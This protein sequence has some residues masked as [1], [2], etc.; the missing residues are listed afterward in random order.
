MRPTI[1]FY[2]RVEKDRLAADRSAKVYMRVTLDNVQQ[3]RFSTG[4]SIPIRKEFQNMTEEDILSFPTE[5]ADEKTGTRYELFHW[6]NSSSKATKGCGNMQEINRSIDR[7]K[8]RANKAIDEL[9]LMG[10]A[11]TAD[12]FG[13]L[14]K[15][16]TEKISF[17]DY[18]YN[19]LFGTQDHTLTQHTIKTYEAVIGK[20]DNYKPGVKMRDIDV[21]FLTEYQ[22]W[23]LKPKEY[24]V[25]GNN[26]GGAGN[27]QRTAANNLK[28]ISTM[29]LMAVRNGDFAE[30]FYPFMEFKI[31]GKDKK[32]TTRD[33]LEIEEIQE[34][35]KLYRAYY[36]P[37]NEN[38]KL[39]SHAEWNERE[40]NRIIT[41]GEFRV[42]KRFLISCYTSLRFSDT[43][44]LDRKKHIFSKYV[45]QKN[46]EEKL[47]KYYI[48]KSMQ[49]TSELVMI[50]LVDAAAD[51]IEPEKNGLVFER[52]SN[53]NATSFLRASSAKLGS[54][55]S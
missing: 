4:I 13:R 20:L 15:L 45:R 51:L 39:V 48:E 6:D 43:V 8:E 21:K 28:V 36:P 12:S 10:K 52:I 30:K 44:M 7:F 54:I 25:E 38:Y 22:N 19:T 50:P 55:R 42:L 26:I 23:M 49:K 53:Q 32:L 16:P 9:E 14:F 47:Y 41:P 40:K 31:K 1:S 24:D 33:F 18:C 35:E 11:I 5:K 37:S 17:Y 34:L 29:F 27:I 46:S 2:L 3:P